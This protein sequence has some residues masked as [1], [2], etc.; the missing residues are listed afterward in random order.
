MAF[1][2]DSDG[3]KYCVNNGFSPTNFCLEKVF[4]GKVFIDRGYI[5]RNDGNGVYIVFDRSHEKLFPINL[6]ATKMSSNNFLIF[7][8]VLIVD[9]IVYKDVIQKHFPAKFI[10]SNTLQNCFPSPVEIIYNKMRR[11]P[12]VNNRNLICGATL[13]NGGMCKVIACCKHRAVNTT[14]H[15]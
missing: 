14:K 13:K 12:H 6:E 4:Q 9:A 5:D 1:I 8:F 11:H 7:G 10:I 2:L 15:H 3:S